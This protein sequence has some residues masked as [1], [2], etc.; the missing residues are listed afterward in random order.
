MNAGIQTQGP[1]GPEPVTVLATPHE[2][3]RD[4]NMWIRIADRLNRVPARWGPE[5]QHIGGFGTHQNMPVV[6]AT[7]SVVDA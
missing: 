5:L 2:W 1:G 7:A 6:R 4:Q 3:I